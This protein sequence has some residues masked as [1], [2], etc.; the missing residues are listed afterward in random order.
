[1]IL[2]KENARLKLVRSLVRDPRARRESGTCVLEGTNLITEARRAGW[3]FRLVLTVQDASHA[4]VDLAAKLR[5]SNVQVET[6]SSALMRSVSDTESPQGILA[7]V[8]LQSLGFPPDPDF[9]LIPDQVRDPGNL[10]TLLRSAAAAGVQAVLLPPGTTDAFA[11]KVLRAAVGA[12]FRLPI[13]PATWM[14]IQERTATSEVYLADMR[15][16]PMWEV[17]LRPRLTLIIGGEAEGAGPDA[18]Q[19][20]RSR[21]GVPMQDQTESLNAAVAGSILM[22]EVARQRSIGPVVSEAHRG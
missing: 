9:L 18:V 12:H 4:I 22:F 13:L 10:G 17:D 5:H 19:L 2:S 15:G 21:I 7:V 16:R 20:A 1:L 3:V 8:E 6:I 14:E 11:P